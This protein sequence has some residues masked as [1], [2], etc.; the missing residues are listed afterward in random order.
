MDSGPIQKRKHWRSVWTQ[1]NTG[2]ITYTIKPP[3]LTG[4]FSKYFDHKK[5]MIS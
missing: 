2:Y 5:Q 3:V 1:L 4:Q